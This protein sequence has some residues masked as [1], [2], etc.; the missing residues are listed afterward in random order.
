MKDLLASR[1]L[2]SIHNLIALNLK[3]QKNSEDI[4]LKSL[5][6]PSY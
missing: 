1:M 5:S 6:M 2:H 4:L 3:M